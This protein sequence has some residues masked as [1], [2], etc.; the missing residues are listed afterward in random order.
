[1]WSGTDDLPQTEYGKNDILESCFLR[2]VYKNTLASILLAISHAIT[3]I[4]SLPLLRQKSTIIF[5]SNSSSKGLIS[6]AI[7]REEL[8]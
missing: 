4:L 3:F 2:L 5:L 8:S 6:L 7:A 1:M